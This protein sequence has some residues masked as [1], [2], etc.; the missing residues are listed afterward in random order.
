MKPSSTKLKPIGIAFAL[1]LVFLLLIIIATTKTTKTTS[2]MS[3]YENTTFKF[4]V[5]VVPDTWVDPAGQRFWVTTWPGGT[6]CIAGVNIPV[7]RR[8]LT[9]NLLRWSWRG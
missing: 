3:F 1:S 2:G 9:F 6:K 7:A 8:Q 4:M 5:S